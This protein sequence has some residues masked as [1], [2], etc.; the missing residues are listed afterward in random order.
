[1]HQVSQSQMKLNDKSLSRYAASGAPPD[2]EGVLHKKGD[3]HKTFQKRWFVLK[4]NLLFYYERKGDK[5]PI[6]SFKHYQYY[7]YL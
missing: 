3:F 5:D 2:R 4:G 1:M 6:G 7:M